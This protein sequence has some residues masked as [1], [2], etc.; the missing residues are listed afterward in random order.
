[1]SCTNCQIYKPKASL[2][3]AR[4]WILH[5]WS[6]WVHVGSMLVSRLLSCVYR[7][8]QLL[9]SLT[10]GA[11]AACSHSG[12]QWVLVCFRFLSACKTQHKELRDTK[13]S[14]QV[15]LNQLICIPNKYRL[16]DKAPQDSIQCCCFT[17]TC[18]KVVWWSKL[19]KW[20]VGLVGIK[21]VGY[22]M[23]AYGEFGMLLVLLYW[24]DSVVAVQGII[25]Y[26][27][28]ITKRS[29]QIYCN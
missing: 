29:Q 17:K 2:H 19:Y 5:G 21:Y 16:N 27:W 8:L 20:P 23:D 10:S 6:S 11:M 13:C 18:I 15:E 12:K 26:Q 7:E 24:R 4:Q 1:M 22:W 9:G 25:I 3:Y 28:T 14:I